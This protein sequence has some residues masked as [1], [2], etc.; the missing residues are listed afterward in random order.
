MRE[1]IWGQCPVVKE[2]NSL[3]YNPAILLNRY[4]EVSL[5]ADSRILSTRSGSVSRSTGDMEQQSLD[6][7]LSRNSDFVFL[8]SSETRPRLSSMTSKSCRS[9]FKSSFICRLFDKSLSRRLL[10]SNKDSVQ[11]S[12][13]SN[14]RFRNF[15]FELFL[16]IFGVD[17]V[18]GENDCW[19]RLSSN[20]ASFRSCLSKISRPE[21]TIVDFQVGGTGIL[22]QGVLE[23]GGR[24]FTL[25]FTVSY[26]FHF[27]W[28]QRP[29]CIANSNCVIKKVF[30]GY[31]YIYTVILVI[32]FIG[33][34]KIFKDKF[35]GRQQKELEN[36]CLNIV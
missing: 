15:V 18:T 5:N 27:V 19:P 1:Q 25:F 21:S 7:A 30:V 29:Q 34:C 2:Q 23:L 33:G 9:F 36:P 6:I 4:R 35:G 11:V 22:N 28:V 20:S 24:H 3:I 32:G 8:Q 16:A 26:L 17:E 13:D 10:T 31:F 14:F 12:T